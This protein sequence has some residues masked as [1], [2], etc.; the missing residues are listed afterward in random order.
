[1][2]A[3]AEGTA[4]AVALGRTQRA[5]SGCSIV[6]SGASRGAE[7]RPPGGYELGPAVPNGPSAGCGELRGARLKGAPYKFSP[8]AAGPCDVSREARKPDF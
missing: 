3:E 2:K 7:V 4:W 6:E 5:C 1:M 8:V